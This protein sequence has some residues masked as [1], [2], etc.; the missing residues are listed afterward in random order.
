MSGVFPP[1]YAFI[2]L[3]LRVV[4]GILSF[5]G[6]E[7]IDVNNPLITWQPDNDEER[8]ALAVRKFTRESVEQPV[9]YPTPFD[10]IAR[11]FLVSE[12]LF[13]LEK[14]L[15]FYRNGRMDLVQE[16]YID[17]VHDLYYVLELLFAP[18]LSGEKP[19]VAEFLKSLA[20]KEAV[21]RA[22]RGSCH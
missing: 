22:R 20:L 14:P 7:R 10:L 21:E 1:A 4:Q 2:H 9:A 16:R 3:Q 18:G 13:K 15:S 5:F 17:A 6:L 8:K 12:D 11:A 19:V